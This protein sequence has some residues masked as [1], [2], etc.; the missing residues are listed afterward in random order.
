MSANLVDLGQLLSNQISAPAKA[1]TSKKTDDAVTIGD[2]DAYA[3]QFLADKVRTFNSQGGK[4]AENSPMQ[5][6]Q[7][8]KNIFGDLLK[9]KVTQKST[10]I[11]P[12]QPQI[13]END[14]K[15]EVFQALQHLAPEQR[16][17]IMENLQKPVK[18]PL[19]QGE[20]LNTPDK[21]NM[22]AGMDDLQTT[23]KQPVMQNIKLQPQPEQTVDNPVINEAISEKISDKNNTAVPEQAPPAPQ[24]AVQA[25]IT[26][27]N[28]EHKQ[29]PQQ[30]IGNE[31]AKAASQFTNN[32]QDQKSRG[33]SETVENI[34]QL[35]VGIKEN[36]VAQGFIP[37]QT[38]KKS[39]NDPI[40]N[41]T[42]TQPS[43]NP[44]A[45]LGKPVIIP[46]IYNS[47]ENKNINQTPVTQINHAIRTNLTGTDRDLTVT[48][49]PP[50][51]GKVV[52]K[53]SQSNQEIIG[54]LEVESAQ[55]KSEIEKSMPEIVKTLQSAGVN[56]R[57]VEITV[58]PKND[59]GNFGD[60]QSSQWQMQQ[61]NNNRSQNQSG[62][63]RDFGNDTETEN[64]TTQ[65]EHE[66]STQISDSDS[67]NLYM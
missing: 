35:N 59:N 50:E 21:L 15:N 58:N 56:I 10:Q 3:N 25:E 55:L 13:T 24:K 40:K 53:F 31:V 14:V 54:K 49:S 28:P 23:G 11:L 6:P 5:I 34:N 17:I 16:Q 7:S 46:K 30:N 37:T 64:Q 38:N 47:I 2:T 41:M 42:I 62:F 18:I 44:D 9:D 12:D 51:L 39:D 1:K 29:T 26:Q 43:P 32:S 66:K 48:L 36:Q 67:L 22:I 33:M 57:R 61:Q 52:I 19:P 27:T 63:E 65:T 60:D 4:M 45:P 20:N 8:I